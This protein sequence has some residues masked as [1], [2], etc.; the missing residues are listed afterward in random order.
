MP[1]LVNPGHHWAHA[2]LLLLFLLGLFLL[3][4]AWPLFFVLVKSAVVKRGAFDMVP[5]D[6]LGVK[7]GKFEFNKNVE[8]S[9]CGKLFVN[10]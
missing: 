10:F 9:F 7:I 4:L 3:R 8:L 5:K 6:E 2:R 1:L